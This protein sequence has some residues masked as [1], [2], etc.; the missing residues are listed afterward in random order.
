MTLDSELKFDKHINKICNIVNKKLNALHRIGSQMMFRSRNFNNK[1][2]GLY[3]KALRIGYGNYKS[4]FDELLEEGGSFNI[5]HKNVETLAIEIDK[6]LNG[7]SSQI[8]NE[9]FQ[10]KLPT[11]YNLKDKNDLYSRN[12]KT[13]T[14][15][16][17]SVS[18]MAPRIW[19]IVPQVLEN[20]Q[21]ISFQKRY[22]EMETKLSHVGYAKPICNM[23][24]LYNKHVWYLNKNIFYFVI[25]ML[26]NR[27]ILMYLGVLFFSPLKDRCSLKKWL[28]NLLN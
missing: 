23:L 20:Y 9:V 17:D 3:E 18:F 11:P 19:S 14:Y 15:G 10:F 16:T 5:Y 13:L 1:I 27:C 21:S 24:V 22:K 2:K 26:G 12:P 28:A 7:L 6:F 4:K 25:F 8:T